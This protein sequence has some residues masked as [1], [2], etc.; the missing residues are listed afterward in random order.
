MLGLFLRVADD[1]RKTDRVASGTNY[2]TATN[3][4]ATELR[5]PDTNAAFY[6]TRHSN[7]ASTE[8]TTFKL[9]ILSSRGALT[10]PRY[11][12]DITLDGRESKLLATDFPFGSKT[13]LYSTAEILSYS[14]VD[15]SPIIALWLPAGEFGEFAL[16]GG[17]R[18]HTILSSP[19]GRAQPTF[20]VDVNSDL[21]VAYQQWPEQTIIQFDGFKAIL[22]SRDSAFRFWA[23][24]L[25]K[26][27][28]VPVNQTIFVTGPYLVRG[29]KA[30]GPILSLTGDID[31][32]TNIEIWAPKR[33]QVVKWNNKL[34]RSTRTPQGSL[35]VHLPKPSFA[36]DD[37]RLDFGTWKYRDG[38]PE[39]HPA[40]DD[41]RWVVADHSTT[42]NPTK[43][44]TL[45]VLYSDDYGFHTG[46]HIW[47]GYFSGNAT[48]VR[49]VV[50]GGTA[51][52]WSAWLNGDYVGSFVGNAS[53]AAGDLTL[54]F[55]NATVRDA[56]VLVVL[57]DHS[58]HNQRAEA[59]FPRGILQ[60]SLE[61]ADVSFSK[62]TLAGNAGGEAN[63]D[64]IRGNIAEGALERLGWHLPGFDDSEWE[65]RT[66]SEGVSTAGVGFF[67]TTLNFDI[68]KGHD[69]PLQLEISSP[70][71]SLL[72][73]QLY[74]NGSVQC[75]LVTLQY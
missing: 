72:R 20:H 31:A 33:A 70:T 57:Q 52:G 45:P 17:S 46:Y 25:S 59:L 26:D 29:V 53:A 13:L 4:L 49:L 66:P 47:R 23:P 67:R 39:R 58:G 12:N 30:V 75:F 44:A 15:G 36:V 11:S 14:V 43:P 41:S 34:V 19:R 9:N 7:S 35:L 74:V 42:P 40:Y 8:L 54:P 3:V 69:V 50:Q 48:A 5:N 71:G 61:G 55:T 28:L 32:D 38:L 2:T 18:K 10:I 6:I 27:P 24:S 65:S 73:A 56:N 21:V 63:I 51:S 62:W 60:A 37:L 22:L 64:P 16:K 68:P 1:L